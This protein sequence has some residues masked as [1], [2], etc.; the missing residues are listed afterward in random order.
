[1]ASTKARVV[2][3]GYTVLSY[4]ASPIAYCEGWL[5]EKTQVSAHLVMWDSRIN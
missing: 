1:M 4:N 5:P 3:S 2:G